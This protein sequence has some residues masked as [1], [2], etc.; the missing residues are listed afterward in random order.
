MNLLSMRYSLTYPCGPRRHL[1]CAAVI[2]VVATAACAGCVVKEYPCKSFEGPDSKPSLLMI[3]PYS[4]GAARRADALR[5]IFVIRGETVTL[6]VP[7]DWHQDP[8]GNRSWRMWLHALD[9]LKP[10]LFHYRETG[11]AVALERA[12]E[13]ALDWIDHNRRSGDGISEFAWY[14][15]SV[16]YRAVRLAYLYRALEYEQLMTSDQ[17][18]QLGC[19]VN[20]HAYWLYDNSNYAYGNN[21]GL[22]SDAGLFIVAE[23]L[24]LH[25]DAVA[26]RSRATERFVENV[27]T[28]VSVQDG[29]HLEHSPV[30]HMLISELLDKLINELGLGTEQL[31]VLSEKMI[32]AA[33]WFVMPDGLYPQ[34]GDTDLGP[35]PQW[36]LD[37]TGEHTGFRAFLDAGAAIYRD[38][39][40]YFMTTAWYH[41]RGH[42]H[43][44][45]ASFVWAEN[46]RR[47]IVDTGRYGYFYEETGRIYAESSPAHSTLT[48]DPPFDKRHRAPYGSGVLDTATRGGWH[49]VLLQ[50]PI[51]AKQFVDHRRVF[52]YRPGLWLVVIDQLVVIHPLLPDSCPTSTR[53]FHFAPRLEVV[54]LEDGAVRLSDDE[55]SVWLQ[56]AALPVRLGAI[57]GQTEP[58]VQ[59]VTFP[60]E[61]NWVD[62]TAVEVEDVACIEPMVVALSIGDETRP[63]FAATTQHNDVSIEIG[64]Q[65][66]RLDYAADLLTLE[67]E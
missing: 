33:P 13:I 59:G 43:A 30:Y 47:L 34:F 52:A 56:T 8:F 25:P 44:D 14:D 36:A 3:R 9:A 28:T 57:R 15:M 58:T 60:S 12:L 42:K 26:W 11:E 27:T 19:S 5:G 37:T 24:D 20:E 4:A 66:L 67:V 62:S 6:Q 50:N 38:D 31:R 7:I 48:I 49:A 45:D 10:L 53:R 2:A 51:L 41:S 17:R 65:R 21:H 29:V 61:R 1:R 39:S 54:Q 16:A 63:V 55:D 64:D 46:G 35:A 22:Y 23:Q 40:S 32:A 18:K